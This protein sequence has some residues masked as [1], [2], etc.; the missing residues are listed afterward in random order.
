MAEIGNISLHARLS[1]EHL[2]HN[3]NIDNFNAHEYHQL[4]T[5]ADT[6]NRTLKKND[7]A[8]LRTETGFQQL[9]KS[10]HT[11]NCA[12]VSAGRYVASVDFFLT[13]CRC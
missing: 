11:L 8:E 1:A 13:G 6:Y 3:N 7:K 4:E 12:R 5:D 10:M 9:I 2:M